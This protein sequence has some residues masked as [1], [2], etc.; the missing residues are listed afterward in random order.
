MTDMKLLYD[1]PLSG[2]ECLE[3]FRMEGPG[4]MTFPHGRLRLES[5]LGPSEGLKANFVL[6]CPV[7]FPDR[8]AISWEFRP[9]REPGLAMLFFAASGAGGKDL[10]DPALAPR[11]GQ[12]EQYHH[13]E[14]NAYHAA[15][16][17]RALKE[18]RALH[19]CNLRKS[20]GLHL[21]AQGADPIPGA[22]DAV[23]PY[24]ISL[25]KNGASIRFLINELPIFDWTDDGE[26]YGPV[27]GGGRIGLRQLAPMIGDYA[28][29]QVCQLADEKEESG[30]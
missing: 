29:L 25:I 11:D 20:Y 16:F 2:P 6:W 18:E 19:V 28:H 4:E 13:G 9:V 17:R 15:Y 7:V 24:R 26:A 8:I 23:E 30:A 1:N 14:M 27:L 21:V 3:G 5:R 12:Y 22:E 10:F